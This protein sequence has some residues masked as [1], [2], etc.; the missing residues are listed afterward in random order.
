MILGVGIDLLNMGRIEELYLKFNDK[1][2][3]KILSEE[4][5]GDYKKSKNK[6]NFLAKKF[7]AKEAFSKALGTGI[8]RGINF[9]DITISNDI[10][11]KPI[12]FLSDNGFSFLENLFK[13]NAKNMQFD[14]SITDETPFVNCFVVISYNG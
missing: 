10:L 3:N 1:L 13:K 8:G 11:G 6:I 2:A 4:E 14:I 5:L 12:V 7:C 9:A